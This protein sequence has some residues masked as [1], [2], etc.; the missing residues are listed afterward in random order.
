MVYRYPNSQPVIGISLLVTVT[1]LAHTNIV[2]N[3][4]RPSINC[5]VF[6]Q[7]NKLLSGC[8]FSRVNICCFLCY[9]VVNST[10][11]DH[12]TTENYTN[13]E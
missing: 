4:C 6:Y 10:N 5:K 9:I 13:V 11:S 2:V 7:K 1:G 8:S 12:K 3:T